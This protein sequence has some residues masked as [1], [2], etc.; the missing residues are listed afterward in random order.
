MKLLK[1]KRIEFRL[2]PD[3]E[4]QLNILSQNENITPS[5]YLRNIIRNQSGSLILSEDQLEDLKKNFANLTRVGSNI[6]Q[7][8]YHLNR[9]ALSS[10]N[11]EGIML[12]QKEEDLK[13]HLNKTSE[14]ITDLKQ[15]IIKLIMNHN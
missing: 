8:A 9:K 1:S 4:K 3:E 10:E 2:T 14:Q 15:Q 11:R 12:Q 5:Q 6:N 7:I 13:T